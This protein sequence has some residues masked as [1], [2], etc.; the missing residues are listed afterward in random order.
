MHNAAVVGRI[1]CIGN[2]KAQLQ[3]LVNLERPV[4]DLVLEGLTIQKLHRDKCSR[5]L[6][7]DVIDGADVGVI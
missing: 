7:A 2:L 4:L 6:L 1:E 3:Q 5:I